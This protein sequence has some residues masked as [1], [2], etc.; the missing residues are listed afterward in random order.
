MH[1]L[2]QTFGLLQ[3]L[4]LFV[5]IS[6]KESSICSMRI[7]LQVVPGCWFR[8]LGKENKIGEKIRVPRCL[9]KRDSG[10]VIYF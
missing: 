10:A 7:W 9:E 5:A 2:C 6:Q 8:K 3:A 4:G 1:G